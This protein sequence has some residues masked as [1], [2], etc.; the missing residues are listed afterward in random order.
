M[1]RTETRLNLGLFGT[2]PS[3]INLRANSFLPASLEWLQPTSGSPPHSLNPFFI[4]RSSVMTST[5]SVAPT[6]FC[7]SGSYSTQQRQQNKARLIWHSS[8]WLVCNSLTSTIMNG[9]CFYQPA[10]PYIST[11]LKT[12]KKRIGE[13]GEPTLLT[14][15]S[16][17]VNLPCVSVL[18]SVND[19]SFR[20][21]SVWSTELEKATFD[22][23]YSWPV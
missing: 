15:S 11:Y 20:M 16:P 6:A 7:T 17:I 22:F 8:P 21:A 4:F 2:S 5:G 12:Y 10:A 3:A 19:E 23:V 1:C 18:L 13:G 9:L 14:F